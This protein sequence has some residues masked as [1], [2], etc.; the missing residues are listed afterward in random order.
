MNKVDN[1]SVFK[2]MKSHKEYFVVNFFNW[3]G[4]E[5]DQKN[6]LTALGVKSSGMALP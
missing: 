6:I 5:L 2:K 4:I 3:R 1:K